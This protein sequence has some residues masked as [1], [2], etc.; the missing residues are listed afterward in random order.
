MKSYRSRRIPYWTI[1]R[2]QRIRTWK[3]DGFHFRWVNCLSSYILLFWRIWRRAIRLR[4]SLRK[5]RHFPA[6]PTVSSRNNVWGTSAK[7]LYWSLDTTQI[8]I[9]LLFGWKFTSTN[10]KCYQDLNTTRHQCGISALVPQ[11]PFRG[12]TVAGVSKSRQLFSQ[13]A[14]WI[15][16]L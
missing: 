9:V 10:Q 1:R 15:I 12:E 13:P 16:R 6:P 2:R 3:R 11:T 14:S 8:W 4:W 5:R 7:I